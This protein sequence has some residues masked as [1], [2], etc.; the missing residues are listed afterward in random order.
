MGAFTFV[1]F[2][3]STI[4]KKKTAKK[5]KTQMAVP[6]KTSHIPSALQT[7]PVGL[8]VKRAM[9]V[10]GGECESNLPLFGIKI[11]HSVVFHSIL[12]TLMSV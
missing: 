8:N 5:N 12:P 3:S 7:L 6:L 2:R 11:S 1:N 10:G 4:T 9:G